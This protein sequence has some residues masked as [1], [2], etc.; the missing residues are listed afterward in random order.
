MSTWSRPSTL[1]TTNYSSN[2]SKNVESPS[3]YDGSHPATIQR[4]PNQKLKIGKSDG[5][6]SYSVG[7]KKGDDMAP[8]LFLFLMQG[9]HEIL[10]KERKKTI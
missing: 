2:S 9:L 10:E 4:C 5:T 3:T 8:V 7:V 6:I 1:P